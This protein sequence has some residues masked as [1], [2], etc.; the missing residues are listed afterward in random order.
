MK[1]AVRRCWRYFG[2]VLV[3]V[4]IGIVGDLRGQEASDE[5]Q[6]ARRA[7]MILRAGKL[8]LQYAGMPD[9][10]PLALSK[11]PVLRTNDP[12]RNELD[13]GLWLWFDGQRP[14]AALI[15]TY[16]ASRKWNY[17]NV[18]LTDEALSLRGRPS[19]SWQPEAAVREWVELNEVVPEAPRARQLAL[20][21]LP[22]PFDVSEVRRGERF[23][24]RLVGQPIYVYS[25]P[26]SNL[27]DGA[28]FVVSN[29]TNPEVMIQVEARANG[30]E[31]RWHVAF[32]RLTAAEATV[33][34]GDKML[35]KVPPIA[36]GEFAPN[37]GYYATN[38]PDRPESSENATP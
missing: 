1:Q 2:P 17:E 3:L 30:G 36:V 9:H 38:E 16:Y 14:I 26:E 6:A 34:L 29:G 19:W 33:M 7:A 28:L 24:L 32:A 18:T 8:R 20:R 4:L 12:T 35:W 21:A 22:R 31:R 13:G 5:E 11:S 10:K 15:V 25:D 37:A 27:L 23:P